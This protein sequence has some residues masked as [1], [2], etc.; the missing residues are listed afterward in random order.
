MDR[1][2]IASALWRR[3]SIGSSGNAVQISSTI[4][5]SAVIVKC[6]IVPCE[7]RTDLFAVGCGCGIGLSGRDRGSRP[8]RAPGVF[9][10]L[11]TD[12]AVLDRRVDIGRVVGRAAYACE[13]KRT[14]VGHCDRA[15]FF[16]ELQE[17]CVAQGEPRLIEGVEILEDQQR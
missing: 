17:S 14:V 9:E 11:R 7:F 13:T 2:P 4:A 6:R 3:N 8:Y 5:S 10:T 1:P 15:G 16:A 12:P